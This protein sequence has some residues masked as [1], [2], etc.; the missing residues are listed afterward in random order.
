MCSCC[1]C[2]VGRRGLQ[3]YKNAAQHGGGE[4]T[5]TQRCHHIYIYIYTDAHGREER[6][7]KRE[8]RRDPAQISRRGVS[9]RGNP[10]R[11]PYCT[12]RLGHCVAR[13]GRS[14]ARRGNTPNRAHCSIVLCFSRRTARV[15]RLLSSL[16]PLERPSTT[17]Y[18]GDRY[19]YSGYGLHNNRN[20]NDNNTHDRQHTVLATHP[21]Q[22][23]T[24]TTAAAH[25]G[26]H[27][28]FQITTH[29]LFQQDKRPHHTTK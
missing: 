15:S 19:T 14:V 11:P 12:T 8:M 24:T 22:G 13:L 16:S 2:V 26:L 17:L 5:S 29:Y 4:R 7:G 6:R 27:L 3:Q 10:G 1:V 20:N 21:L 23:P 28:P 18:K 9:Q 25:T